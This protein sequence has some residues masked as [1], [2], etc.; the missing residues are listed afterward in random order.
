MIIIN[1][2]ARKHGISDADMEHAIKWSLYTRA[3]DD[4]SPTRVLHVGPDLAGNPIEIVTLHIE[5]DRAIAIHAM[6]LTRRFHWI[7]KGH[8]T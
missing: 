5:K 3:I 2:S 8:T 7:V 6:R 4:D 1:S